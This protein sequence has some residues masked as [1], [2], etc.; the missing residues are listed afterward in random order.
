MKKTLLA[1]VLLLPFTV[2]SQNVQLFQQFNGQYDFTA[3][4]NT[5][6]ASPNPC[7]IQANS[8]ED[9]NLGPTETFIS[10]HLYW[11]GPGPADLNVRLN[12]AAVTASRQFSLTAGTGIQ[13]FGAYADV[14]NIVAL[15]GNGTYTFSDL[16]IDLAASGACNNGTDFAGW[17]MYIIFEDPALTQNQ[18]SLFDGLEF[19]SANNPSLDISLTNIEAASDDLSKIGFLAWEGDAGIANN[20]T[21]LINGILIDN[22]PLNPGDNA[23]N[24]TNAYTNSAVNFNMDL[25]F[26]S[27][28]NIVQPGDTSILIQLTSS[29]DFVMVNNLITVVNSELPDATITI[30]GTGVVCASANNMNVDYT[31]YNVNSTAPLPAGTPIAFYADGVLAGQSQT[32]NEIPIGGSESNGIIITIPGGTPVIFDLLAVVDD[33]GTGTGIV[34]ETDESNNEFTIQIDLTQGGLNLGPDVEGCEGTAEILD[35]G[36]S[37]PNFSWQWFRNGVLIPGETNSTLSV[38][39]DGTYVVEGFEGICFVTDEI[40]VHFNPQP[41][42]NQPDNLYQCNDGTNPGDYDLTLNDAVV[43][44][45]QD[46][47]LFTVIYYETFL[48][49]DAGTNPILNPINYNITLPAPQTIYVRIEGQL[50]ICY[51][52]AEFELRFPMAIPGVVPSPF[53]VCDQDQTGSEPIDLS[54]EFDTSVLNGEPATSYTI[55]YHTSQA[56]ADGGINPLPNPYLVPVPGQTIFIRLENITYS[57]EYS[58]HNTTTVDIIVNEVPMLTSDPLIECENDNNGFTEFTLSDADASITLGDPDLFVTYHGTPLDAINDANELPDPYVND[59]IYNDTVYARVASM[60]SSCIAVVELDLEVRFMPVITT[61]AEPLRA[62]DNDDGV[63]NDAHPF[64]LTLVEMEVLTGLDPTMYDVYYY[65]DESDAITAGDLALTAPDFSGA[66]TLP[67]TNITNPQ[68]IFILVVGNDLSV[69][70]PNPNG[71]SGC[72]DIVPLT[73]IVDPVPVDL[74]P[75]EAFLCDDDLNGSTLTDEISTFDLTLNDAAVIG[76]DPTLV[77]TWYETVADE[78]M[79]NPIADPTMFQNTITPQ[80]VIARVTTEFGCNITSTLT[81]T[82]LPNPTPN[83]TPIPLEL[84]DDNDDGLISGFGLGFDLTLADA[85]IIGAEADVSV[86]Y[87]FDLADAQAGI[88][89]TELVSPYGNVVPNLQTVYARVTRDVPPGILPC[90]TIVPLDLIVIALPDMPAVGFLD[91]MEVCDDN[92]DG[93]AIFDLTLNDPFVLGIQDPAD[94]VL[95]ITYYTDVADANAGVNAILPADVVAFPSAGQ[96]IW[97][98]LESS[99]TGCARVSSFE[100]VV[101][102][103]PTIGVGDDLFLCDDEI[104]DSTP[105]DGLSTFNLTLNTDLIDLGDGTLDV[106]YFGS[107]PDQMAGIV[108]A[109]PEA[110]QNIIAVQQEIFVSVFN[111]EGCSALT[112]F[113][114]NVEPNPNAITPTP[115]RVCD[116]D[117]DGFFTEFDLTQKDIEIANGETDVTVAY[118]G[119]INDAVLGNPGDVLPN[120]YSN[121]VPFN[122]TVYARVT[123]DVPPGVLP[124]FTIV[125]LELIID[126]L[127]AVP[128]NGFIDPMELCDDDGDGEAIFDLTLNDPFVLGTQDPADFVDPITYYTDVADADAGI[129]AIL[130]VDAMAFPSTGQT[131]WVRLEN[132]NTGCARVSSF[133]LVVAPLPV[134]GA[135]PFD[136]V[137]CDDEVGGSTSTDGI[138]TFNL[139]LNDPDITLG[140]G[141]LSVFYYET[142]DDQNNNVPIADPTAYQNVLDNPQDIFVTVFSMAGCE[143]RTNLTLRVLPNP[144]PS[145]PTALE[146]C[147]DDRDGFAEFDLTSKDAE[148]LNSEPDVSVLYYIDF[149]TAEAG[150]VDTELLSPY[151]NEV[152]N[153]QIVYA[154]VTR[155]VPPGEL[156]CFTIVELELIVNPLPDD[157]VDISDVIDCQV[158]FVGTSSIMLNTKDDEILNGQDGSIFTVFYYETQADADAMTNA[159]ASDTFYPY[160]TTEITLYVG[161]LN[162]VTG[163]YITNIDG[164]NDLSFTLVVKQGATATSPAEPYTVCDTAPNDGMAEFDLSDPMLIGEILNGQDPSIYDLTFHQTPEEADAGTGALP[165][166]YTNVINPQVI[167]VRVTNGDNTAPQCY[168]VAEVILNVDQAPEIVLDDQYRLCVDEFGTPIAE[169]FGG[170]SPPLID[171]GL[172]PSVYV[173]TWSLDGVVLAGEFGPSITA[174]AGGLYEVTATELLSGCSTT[175][176][177]TVTVSSAPITFDAQVVTGAFASSHAIEATATGLGV[178]QFQ[179]D[180]GPFQSSGLFEDVFPGTH[181]ITIQDVNGCGSVIIE[182]GVIDYPRFVT[183][184]QDGYHDTWNIIGIA[185]SDPSA[186]I[187]IFDRNGKLLKQVSPLGPG[188]DGTYNGNPLPSSDYWFL[189]EYEEDQ[190]IKEFR[191]HFT[192]KR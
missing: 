113:F 53:E 69:T 184:N 58:C 77:V 41:V 30:D 90:F 93:E 181:T 129:N 122:E 159:I 99:V 78:A 9:L 88:A 82:V 174:V 6:N 24:G 40:E 67:Y 70:P 158:P 156:P 121:V 5:L 66:L 32:I 116:E 175:A 73:L 160:D 16:N 145:T 185:D 106:Q 44:G 29:Q 102:T 34:A 71:A 147:D 137:L 81:L 167:Y 112:S 86:L 94:F 17:A 85:D 92:G 141:S 104:N 149:A 54:L 142:M 125:E 11:S 74:G 124:C 60:T 191:G 42:A 136:Q 123:R 172:D 51:D 138:S 12:G 101:G 188:W 35:T 103:F 192:L 65:E 3:V 179:L 26:Y 68:V 186:K 131:I 182:I 57:P 190:S 80:T 178:Y 162:T 87:Y 187:Y 28:E 98:R 148:I 134:L 76:A 96:T 1:L 130:A 119:T 120:P 118:Y 48:D 114:I 62:C 95:P 189:V 50:G 151:T 140:D 91:P 56:E 39:M 100:L 127:P 79:D 135:G 47:T 7:F 163:C 8:S 84:C 2:L 132:I 20:E 117:N 169:E 170:M 33:D 139:S 177:T 164:T 83:T 108:I 21:L 152:A 46:P 61:P 107:L 49:S 55:T 97:V 64:D 89:G 43:L 161:I 25:D 126:Q 176:Q 52:L 157:S 75:F 183:P 19:V 128:A 153:N 105:T 13:Y 45:T 27:L 165:T 110:Y 37:N 23:F 171:T 155:D 173:F 115:L 59:D 144:T 109:T 4:G 22:P 14:S 38:T 72:Y 146:V 143:A 10:A 18:I 31:V 111:G 36:I 168:D 180:T 166:I 154:R 63:I 150:V 133:E 15:N